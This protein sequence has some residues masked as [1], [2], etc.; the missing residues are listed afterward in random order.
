MVVG[1]AGSD[2]AHACWRDG[3]RDRSLGNSSVKMTISVG[4]AHELE[5]RLMT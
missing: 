3:D 4:C 2:V 5:Q 1:R